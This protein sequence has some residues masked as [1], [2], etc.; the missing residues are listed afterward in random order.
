[1]LFF[2]LV[3][4]AHQARPAEE[5]YLLWSSNNLLLLHGDGYKVSASEQTTLTVEHA[6]GWRFGDLFF[7]ADLTRFN[8]ASQAEAYYGEFSP[9]FSFSKL[10]NTDMRFGPVSDVLI[11]SI[12]E[13][14]TGDVEGLLIG[15]GV[16]LEIPGFDFFQL[17]LYR[18]FIFNDRDGEV[19][20]L[21]PAWRLATPFLGSDL[22]FEGYID[23][24]FTS[25][26]NYRK[27]FHFNP[28]LKYD[29]GGLLADRRG[30]F[31]VGAEYS[32]WTN[33]YG[34]PDTPQFRTD[35]NTLSIF[36]NVCF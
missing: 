12:V 4:T 36:L 20:Q 8:D 7:F 34:I 26:G 25:D 19:L 15:P 17:N 3:L 9:R 2:A 6:S 32:Y 22:V 10:G 28:R 27:N 33:K 11:A 18:R 5:G 29:V 16:N 35:E 31:F 30:A 13:F 23:W 1:M 21:T 24:N 14:G